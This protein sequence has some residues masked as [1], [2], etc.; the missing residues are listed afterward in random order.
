VDGFKHINRSNFF[1]THAP[2]IRFETIRVAMYLAVQ[3]GWVIMQYD[4]SRRSARLGDYAV[5][6]AFLHGEFTEEMYME[7]P[8]GC[9]TSGPSYVCMLIKVLYGLWQA[10]HIRNKKLHD[11]LVAIGLTRVESDY[12]LYARHREGETLI[13]IT[14]YAD[15]LLLMD[16]SVA[17]EEARRQL[18]ETLELVEL[19]PVKYLLGI[20]VLIKMQKKTVFFG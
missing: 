17:C 11:C 10:P 4:V 1:E 12:G 18:R 20:E 8:A 9:S 13:L 15:D 16:P 14:V 19:G 5:K 7:Q 2:V 6:T 3:R